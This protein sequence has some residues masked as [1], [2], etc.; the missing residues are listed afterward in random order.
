MT[1]KPSPLLLLLAVWLTYGSAVAADVN[2]ELF[3]AASSGDAQ[4]VKRYIAKGADVNYVDPHLK[5]P[6]LGMT[7]IKNQTRAAKVLLQHGA[8]PNI[9]I[10][11]QDAHLR[12][13]HMTV[14]SRNLPLA[15]ELVGHG[16]KLSLVDS[17]GSTPL[18][19]AA[20]EN[21]EDFTRYFLEAGAD[22][23]QKDSKKRTALHWAAFFGHTDIAKVLVDHGAD[24]NAVTSDGR[25]ALGLVR[26][27]G[28]KSLEALLLKAGAKN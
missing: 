3:L 25:T 20:S 17:F 27:R 14:K 18:I 5:V 19:M 2:T 24:V 15:K 23:N 26:K 7:V 1:T 12:P 11:L 4:K 28:D 6:V 9:K 21:L 16:A 22:V 8:D 10:E 13:L